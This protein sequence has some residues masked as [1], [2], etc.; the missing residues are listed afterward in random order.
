MEVRLE[1]SGSKGEGQCRL[2]TSISTNLISFLWLFFFLPLAGLPLLLALLHLP[3]LPPLSSA[4]LQPSSAVSFLVF[5]F[6]CCCCAFKRKRERKSNQ[7]KLNF[8][9]SKT[10]ATNPAT[11]TVRPP[12]RQGHTLYV[13]MYVCVCVC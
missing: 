3:P 13:H 10:L 9:H 2:F 8:Q 7:I 5:F 11:P 12:H 6:F 4:S 1:R